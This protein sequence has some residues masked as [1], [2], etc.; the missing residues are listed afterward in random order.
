MTHYAH[1]F[2][3]DRIEFDAHLGF[4][5]EERAKPQKVGVSMRFYFPASPS[6]SH[7]DHAGF[8]DY[9]EAVKL[10]EQAAGARSFN[11]IE[12]MAREMFGI[13][14]SYLDTHHGE[15]IKLWLKLTKCHP[16]IP[17]VK[18]GASFMLSDLPAGASS[19]H[20]E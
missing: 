11:L 1:I 7:D 10:V 18:S 12:Y 20:F 6:W 14:R 8:I 13:V 17:A 5:A 3:V 9:A 15:D 4:Y 16:P 2:S 19:V